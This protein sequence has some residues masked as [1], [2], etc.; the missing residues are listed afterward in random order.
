M[1]ILYT[2]W[3]DNSQQ[4]PSLDSRG[5]KEHQ[6]RGHSLQ[7]ELLPIFVDIKTF[8]PQNFCSNLFPAR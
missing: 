7:G 8:K 6:Q 5:L 2:H 1:Y 3:D 4:E